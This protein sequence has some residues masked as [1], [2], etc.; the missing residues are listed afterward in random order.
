MGGLGGSCACMHQRAHGSKVLKR[1]PQE[2]QRH[3][4]LDQ[5]EPQILSGKKKAQGA[6]K[7][8]VMK[9]TWGFS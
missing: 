6:R 4:Q 5:K 2:I 3:M 9:E 1:D 8:D 7:K